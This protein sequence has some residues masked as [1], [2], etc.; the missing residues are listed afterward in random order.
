[1]ICCIPRVYKTHN[2]VVFVKG[3]E[4]GYFAKA[5]AYMKERGVVLRR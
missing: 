5:H 1:M 2:I 3:N 4:I